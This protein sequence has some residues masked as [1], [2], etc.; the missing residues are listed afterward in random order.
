MPRAR[1]TRRAAPA[2]RPELL[3]PLPA[4]APDHSDGVP[5]GHYA[6][7]SY[8]QTQE[9][10]EVIARVLARMTNEGATFYRTT[11]IGD[12]TWYEGWDDQPERMAPFVVPDNIF[13][14]RVPDADSNGG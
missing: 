11:E 6:M 14:S 8:Q 3:A 1:R 9:D 10:P 4:P 2:Q 13:T 5:A 12:C 7:V